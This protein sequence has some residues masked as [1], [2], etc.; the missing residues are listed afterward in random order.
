MLDVFDEL[1]TNA[2][3]PSSLSKWITSKRGNFRDITGIQA[4]SV[5]SIINQFPGLI[6][7]K[8]EKDQADPWL[9]ALVLEQSSQSNLFMPNQEIVI[10]S[11]ED[12]TST[13]KIPAVCKHYDIRHF[14]LFE[15]FDYNGWKITFNKA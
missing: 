1:T 7:W 15:F 6:D 11:Q 2:K 12:K 4:Q 13:Q 9:I 5:A 14:D 3:R 8:H 10:V